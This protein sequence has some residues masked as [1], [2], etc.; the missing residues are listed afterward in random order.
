MVWGK[1]GRKFHYLIELDL[2]RYVERGTWNS[3]D[4]VNGERLVGEVACVGML[5]VLGSDER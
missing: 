1:L 3:E 4:C 2:T 5:V